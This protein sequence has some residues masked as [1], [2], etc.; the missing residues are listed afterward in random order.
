M[1]LCHHSRAGSRAVHR[2]SPG[3]HLFVTCVV[4]LML[5]SV[6]SEAWELATLEAEIF[7]SDVA[8]EFL[9]SLGLRHWNLI[10]LILAGGAAALVLSALAG[11]GAL[12]LTTMRSADRNRPDKIPI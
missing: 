3:G 12:V 1:L 5:L 10:E 11:A 2:V 7:A 4:V 8:L 6:F 9:G